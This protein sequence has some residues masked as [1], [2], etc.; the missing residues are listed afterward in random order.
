MIGLWFFLGAVVGSLMLLIML[1]A[2]RISEVK[3]RILTTV[4]LGDAGK[5]AQGHFNAAYRG[6]KVKLTDKTI[7]YTSEWGNEFEFRT[8]SKFGYKVLS[9]VICRFNEINH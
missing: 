2:D 3:E 1:L 4:T 7:A 6:G 5:D 8:H 9:A